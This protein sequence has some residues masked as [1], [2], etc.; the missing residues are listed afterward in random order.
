[1]ADVK[2]TPTPPSTSSTPSNASE[3]KPKSGS[4]RK[5]KGNHQAPSSK[6]GGQDHNDHH[7]GDN[8]KIRKK[9]E[10]EHYKPGA[11]GSRSGKPEDEDSTEPKSKGRNKRN[12]NQ[13]N[14]QTEKVQNAP[15]AEQ[16]SEKSHRNNR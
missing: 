10:L 16:T 2:A 13:N 9:P 7:G 6:D 4:N 8:L 3:D 12:N 1:M 11:F 15:N 14:E 5:N